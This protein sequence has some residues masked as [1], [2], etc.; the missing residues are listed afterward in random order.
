LLS[1]ITLK[2][3]LW[4]GY[5]MQQI[6]QF[7]SFFFAQDIFVNSTGLWHARKNSIALWFLFLF[8]QKQVLEDKLY[9]TLYTGGTWGLL[10]FLQNWLDQTW[11]N[12]IQFM[13]FLSLL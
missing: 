11:M 8:E 10:F 5:L 9:L 3:F 7:S 6:F 1:F 2:G 13:L 4:G 12:I